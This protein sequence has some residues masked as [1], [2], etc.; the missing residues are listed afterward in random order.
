MENYVYQVTCRQEYILKYF[1]DLHAKPCGKCDNC[2]KA[3]KAAAKGG[4]D[5]RYKEYL[6]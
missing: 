3:A 2:V 5:Y 4:E 1:G 6:G